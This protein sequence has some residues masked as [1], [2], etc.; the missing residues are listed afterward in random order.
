MF[1]KLF[2]VLFLPFVLYAADYYVQLPT[3]T[4]IQSLYSLKNRLQSV[5]YTMRVNKLNN[6]AYAPFIGAFHNRDNAK[7]AL[8]RVRKYVNRNAQIYVQKTPT[9]HTSKFA[10]LIGA[11]MSLVNATED[12]NATHFLQDNSINQQGFNLALE[13]T[14]NP[15]F[16]ASLEYEN[17]SSSIASLS[18]ILAS[19]NYTLYD[20]NK[21]TFYLGGIGGMSS[22]NW[23][24]L[25]LDN[26]A[27][28]FT[29]TSAI[30]GVTSEASYNFSEY[31]AVVLNARELFMNHALTLKALDK[32]TIKIT[33]TS[34]HTLLLRLKYSF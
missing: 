29:S 23:T 20:K 30:Y 6:Y 24:K 5:G 27:G 15:N 33:Q 19:L 12:S 9:K 32:S 26:V 21:F 14:I 18:N 7:N 25:P 3:Q 2:I 10:L 11:N 1:N 22:L 16:M 13:Y 28:N 34:T 17:L 4:N 31:F 8:Y